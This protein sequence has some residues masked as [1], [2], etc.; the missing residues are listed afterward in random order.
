MCREVSG[1]S[2][3]VSERDETRHPE[4]RNLKPIPPIGSAFEMDTF[5]FQ[6]RGLASRT[7][8]PCGHPRSGLTAAN[9]YYKVKLPYL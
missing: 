6:I 3:Q 2:F 9:K 4:T 8:T 7:K 1:V 5:C